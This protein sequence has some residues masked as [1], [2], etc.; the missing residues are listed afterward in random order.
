MHQH[1]RVAPAGPL[2]EAD[3]DHGAAIE[4]GGFDGLLCF[5][6][7][8]VTLFEDQLKDGRET[9]K[10][11]KQNIAESVVPAIVPFER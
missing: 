6:E 2:E 11:R 10:L 5:F 1:L 4:V 9:G 7:K 3:G 8:R